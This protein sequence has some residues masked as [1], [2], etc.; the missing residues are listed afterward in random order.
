MPIRDGDNETRDQR[1][2]HEVPQNHA[3][4]KAEGHRNEWLFHATGEDANSNG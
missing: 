4:P 1:R 3:R 2:Y